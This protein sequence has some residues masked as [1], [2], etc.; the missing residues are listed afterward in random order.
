MGIDCL[1]NKL[2]PLLDR[3]ARIRQKALWA[4]ERRGKPRAESRLSNETS[5]RPSSEPPSTARLR[6]ARLPRVKC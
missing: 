5:G 6:H 1:G 4:N 3:A 2:G